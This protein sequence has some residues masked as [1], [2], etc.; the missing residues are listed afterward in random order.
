MKYSSGLMPSMRQF[1]ARV[2]IIAAR[3]P[4]P[5]SGMAGAYSPAGGQ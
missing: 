3:G 1:S 2:N 5:L 4:V